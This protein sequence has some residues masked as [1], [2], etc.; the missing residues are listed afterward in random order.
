MARID[1]HINNHSSAHMVLDVVAVVVVVL[2]C[3]VLQLCQPHPQT[4]IQTL[5][6]AACEYI[7]RGNIGLTRDSAT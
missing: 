1:R 7:F 3:F 2:F 5:E 4:S 6:L